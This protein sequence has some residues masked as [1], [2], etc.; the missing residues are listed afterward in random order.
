MTNNTIFYHNAQFHLVLTLAGGSFLNW[1]CGS[2]LGWQ[3]Q[4]EKQQEE[5]NSV[6]ALFFYALLWPNIRCTSILIFLSF[7][8]NKYENM[9]EVL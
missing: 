6:N 1:W 5:E 3:L 7:G 8:V 2:N 4:L 9:A